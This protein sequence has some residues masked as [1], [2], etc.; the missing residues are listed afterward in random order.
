ML[1]GSAPGAEPLLEKHHVPCKKV[2]FPNATHG[3]NASASTDADGWMLDAANF[4]ETQ[5]NG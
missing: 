1:P 4:W 3:V 5:I 2:L